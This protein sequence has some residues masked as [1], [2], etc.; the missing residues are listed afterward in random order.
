MSSFLYTWS[1]WNWIDF[2]DAVQRVNTG[3]FYEIKWSCGRR[4][5]SIGDKDDRFFL[6]RLGQIPKAKKGIIGC[7]HIT[8]KPYADDHFN[9]ER[10][11][12]GKVAQYT[13][14]VFSALSDHPIID[15]D[16]L[17]TNYP[18]INWTPQQS[19]MSVAEDVAEKLFEVI[20]HH[21]HHPN[22]WTSEEV[23]R[24]VEG[25]PKTLTVTTYDRSTKARQACIEKYG[26]GCAV[27]GFTFA[28]MYGDLGQT[29]IQVHHLR[30]LADIGTE[31]EIDPVKDLRPVCAN[32]HCMLHLKSPA[33]SIEELK[34]KLK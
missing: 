21:G 25:K 3:N 5:D 9:P 6:M 18:S 26:Y 34:E 24:Y 11:Q 22:Q 19:A 32:C 14:I 33:Y 15:L 17:E 23:K 12:D 8:S 13:D 20:E 1:S 30:Q 27:C 31:Y 16:T 29:Y 10:L 2:A 4:K 28:S 7:G